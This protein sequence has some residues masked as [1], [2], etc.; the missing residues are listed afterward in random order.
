MEIPD[1]GPPKTLTIV[2]QV[3]ELGPQVVSDG[4][5]LQVHDGN[6]PCDKHHG[7][8]GLV[9]RWL[10]FRGVDI[11]MGLNDFVNGCSIS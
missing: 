2:H 11:L 1:C 9:S 6:V 8:H 7:G 5:R 10:P 3:P 4:V